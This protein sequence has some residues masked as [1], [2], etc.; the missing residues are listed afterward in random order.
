MKY[1]TM[2]LE[3]L[4]QFPELH[5]RLRKSRILLG[6]LDLFAT[7]LSSRHLAWERQIAHTKPGSNQRQVASEALE[8]AVDELKDSLASA[9]PSRETETLSLDNV[10][11]FIGRHTPSG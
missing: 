5:E 9:A 7:E 8:Q 11:A 4:E 1:K 3:L 6:T 2:V 10:M